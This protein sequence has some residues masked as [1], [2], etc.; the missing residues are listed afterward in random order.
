M[1]N[2]ALRTA[3]MVT[4]RA[5][6]ASKAALSREWISASIC[7]RT[8]DRGSGQQRGAA[9]RAASQNVTFQVAATR[10]ADIWNLRAGPSSL[11]VPAFRQRECR[12]AWSTAID[13]P[14]LDL[15]TF[16]GGL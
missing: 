7:P 1:S 8:P 5:T 15:K 10:T 9:R 12:E 13:A 16:D 4:I 11:L 14:L 3:W 6:A 2:H